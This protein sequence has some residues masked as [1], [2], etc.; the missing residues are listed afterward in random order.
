MGPVSQMGRLG[1]D[2][3]A[4]GHAVNPDFG[5][6]CVSESALDHPEHPA[7]RAGGE[8]VAWGPHLGPEGGDK[9]SRV[10]FAL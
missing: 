5:L 2:R 10:Q 4:Q 9:E 7:F 6:L 1:K 3:P 8:A